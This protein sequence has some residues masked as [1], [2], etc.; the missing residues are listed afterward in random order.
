MYQHSKS[1]G[2]TVLDNFNDYTLYS[3]GSFSRSHVITGTGKIKLCFATCKR[4]NKDSFNVKEG[5]TELGD[6]CFNYSS[7]DDVILPSSLEKIGDKCFKSS[8][9]Q[10][11]YLPCNLKKIGHRNFPTT[12]CYLTIPPSIEDF[13][14]DNIAFCNELTSISVDSNNQHFIFK[15]D[16]LYNYDMTEILFCIRKRKG[17]PKKASLIAS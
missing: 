16:I 10:N 12:L 6:G 11:V 9:L 14:F 8:K 3:D 2:P 17:M 1:C 5:I 4:N 13:P 15:D 7:I